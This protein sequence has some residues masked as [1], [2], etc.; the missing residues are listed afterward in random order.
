M[1]LRGLADTVGLSHVF[2]G[3]IER[4]TRPLPKARVGAFAEAVGL[5]TSDLA[6]LDAATLLA[7]ITRL[8]ED[9][10]CS[11]ALEI[12][13]EMAEENGLCGQA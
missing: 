2:V 8:R 5:S 12:V 1:T 3:E 7:V 11:R 13:R 9:G 10:C 6:E 4:G